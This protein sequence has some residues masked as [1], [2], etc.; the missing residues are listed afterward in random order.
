MDDSGST[1]GLLSL[2]VVVVT[3]KPRHL[4]VVFPVFVDSSRF[5]PLSQFFRIV[6]TGKNIT[7]FLSLFFRYAATTPA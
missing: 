1:E 6:G 5:G 2:L 3:S 4:P 7:R